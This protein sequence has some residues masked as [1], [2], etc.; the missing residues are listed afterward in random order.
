MHLDGHPLSLHSIVFIPTLMQLTDDEQKK[1][2]L[3][4]AI[5][6]EI[7]GTYAQTELGH[8]MITFLFYLL[9]YEILFSNIFFFSGF[10]FVNEP[11][12]N[13]F[14]FKRLYAVFSYNLNSN[15]LLLLLYLFAGTNLRKLETTA[16]Y[17]INN[18]QFIIN[19]PTITSTKW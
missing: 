19:S 16:I 18:E 8:G 4:R 10:H 6:L 12:L 14:F 5:N 17:D 13:N 1:K 3:S 11:Y 9:C 15:S 2:W 7:I